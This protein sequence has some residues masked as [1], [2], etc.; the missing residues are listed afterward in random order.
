MLPARDPPQNKGPTQ[1]E[2]EGL[3]TNIP[4]NGQEIKS[5]DINSYIRQNKL[6]NKD[7]KNRQRKPLHNTEGKN[8]SRRHKHCKHTCTQIRNSQ[9]YKE[10][11]GGVQERYRQQHTYSKGF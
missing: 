3:E 1:T 10:N 7:N 6:K 2:S 11:L 4:A 9:I 5:Q 8:S